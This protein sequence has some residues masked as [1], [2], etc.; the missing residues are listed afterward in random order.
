MSSLPNSKWPQWLKKDFF[1]DILTDKNLQVHNVRMATK[2][3]DNFASIM[4]RALVGPADDPAKSIS[5]IVKSDPSLGLS[6]DFT[7][8]FNFFG[9]EIEMY[10]KIVPGLEKLYRDIGK[11][12]VF[13]P[14]CLKYIK[15]PL[16]VIVLDDLTKQGYVMGN[17]QEGFNLEH[18][19][20][21]LAKLAEFHA[22]SVIFKDTAEDF[23]ESFYKGLY[24]ESSRNVFN[25]HDLDVNYN[26]IVN[27]VMSKWK[28]NWDILNKIVSSNY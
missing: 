14:K 27:E 24:N 2:P 17:R 10:N 20:M 9:K 6:E 12:V 19:Q 18:M 3:G 28:Q 16:N 15:T 4:Y 11:H 21:A 8:N 13:G 7:K 1:W 5:L 26:F 25:Q 23:E 22:A